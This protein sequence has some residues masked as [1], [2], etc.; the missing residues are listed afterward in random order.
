MHISYLQFRS[1]RAGAEHVLLPERTQLLPFPT[2]KGPI[3]LGSLPF[4]LSSELTMQHQPTSF[5]V[6]LPLGILLAFCH[7]G[8][9]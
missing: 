5:P 8:S 9:T 3:A 7:R 4:P 6:T 1:Q 2:S